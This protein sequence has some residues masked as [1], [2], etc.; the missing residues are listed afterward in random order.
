MKFLVDAQLPPLLALR[1]RELGYSVAHVEDVALRN[2]DDGSIRTYAEQEGC[3]LITKDRDFV[4]VGSA[5]TE[6]IQIVWVRT[7]NV[8]NRVLLARFSANWTA[9]LEHLKGGSQIVELR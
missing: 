5:R 1:L 9:I 8:S 3:V 4:P 7:G 2:A 6:R